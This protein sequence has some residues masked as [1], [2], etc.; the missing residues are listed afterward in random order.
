[1]TSI[2][3]ASMTGGELS[4]SLQ[5][6]TDLSRYSI[7]MDTLKNWQVNPYGGIFNRSGLEF[8]V[9][10]KNSYDRIRLITFS[11][12]SDQSYCLEL[13]DEYMRVIKDGVQMVYATRTA[14]EGSHLYTVGVD[15]SNSA[16]TYRCLVEH[17]SGTFSTDLAAGKWVLIGAVGAIVEVVTPWSLADLPLL[18][19]TQSADV[20][21]LNCPGHPPYRISR[22]DHDEWTVTV[23]D[24]SKGPFQ[25]LNTDETSTISAS[26]AT[27][28]V[29]LTATKPIFTADRVGKYLYMEIGNYGTPWEV[30]RPVI[31]NQICM[32][33]GRYYK[34][35]QSGNTGTNRPTHYSGTVSDGLIK[36]EYLH[37]GSGIC[38]ITGVSSA[39]L[40]ATATVVDRLPDGGV[41]TKIYSSTNPIT[42]TD[43]LGGTEGYGSLPMR[44]TFTTPHGF[45]TG[46][47]LGVWF[48]FQEQFRKNLFFEYIV[49]TSVS[50]TV[51]DFNGVGFY[52]NYNHL[53]GDMSVEEVG[54]AGVDDSYKWAWQEWDETRGYPVANCYYQQRLVHAGTA[55]KPQTPWLS[56]TADILNFKHP[57]PLMLY[58]DDAMTQDLLVSSVNGQQANEIRHVVGAEKLVVFMASCIVAFGNGSGEPLTPGGNWT[59]DV[60]GAYGA[61]RLAPIAVGDDL[62]FVTDKGGAVR[63]LTLAPGTAKYTGQDLCVMAS[64]LLEGH[65]IEEWCYQDVPNKTVWMVRDDGILLGLTYLK[66]QEVLAW[67]QHETGSDWA[68]SNGIMSETGSDTIESAC[69]VSEGDE[70]ALYLSVKRWRVAEAVDYSHCIERLRLRVS[71][72]VED[73]FFLD[74]GLSYDGNNDSVDRQIYVYANGGDTWLQGEVHN[75]M[76][77]AGVFDPTGEAP[78]LAQVGDH[79]VFPDKSR[80]L[81]ESVV[82]TSVCT[83]SIFSEELPA[84][85]RAVSVMAWGLAKDDF[86]GLYHLTGR[87]I[88]ALA[89]GNTVEGLSVGGAGD[90]TLPLPSVKVHAG[91]SIKADG[92]TLSLDIPPGGGSLMDKRKIVPAVSFKLL[93]SGTFEAG[94]DENSLSAVFDAPPDSTGQTTQELVTGVYEKAISTQWNTT[95][96]VF[97][98]QKDP[99]PV[100]ILAIIPQIQ[101]GG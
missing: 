44:L 58:D 72:P 94:P 83:A 81:I 50:T 10:A 32:A 92:K 43:N 26:A 7:S 60:Q 3:Q 15:V 9:R 20:M 49:A 65:Q 78:T 55:T 2:L 98:R 76:S 70:D 53:V 42:I 101:V 8:I 27:G 24:H 39:G 47:T 41:S 61:S 73:C 31:A 93:N 16:S 84:D 79:I 19:K 66:E 69:V 56:R 67:H 30:N 52:G 23:E 22:L 29:T 87:D 95:G 62:L 86:A 1:M 77:G 38:L 51:L 40:T 37:E 57:N 59:P 25:T 17:T 48:Y 88:S 35:S 21:T 4:P 6:R 71:T 54:S 46:D 18:N 75:V 12:S 28:T 85:Y 96:V 34:S 11:F 36:W 80:M 91:L 100:N 74:S 68:L 97:F 63:N 82:S 89:D 99:L 33:G 64:H 90:F 45:D 5:G 14:W 13:G